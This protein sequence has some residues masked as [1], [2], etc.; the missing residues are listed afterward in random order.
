MKIKTF[1][2][3]NFKEILRDP[4]SLIFGIALPVFL[5]ILMNTIQKKAGVEIFELTNFT[6][7]I[8]VFSFSFITMFSSVL[9]AKDR[10][11]SFLTRLFA[12]PMKA[13]DYII[14]YSLPLI[15]ISILQAIICYGTALILGLEFSIN[16]VYSILILIP[17]SLL[18]I[19]TG[20][21]IGTLC[22]DKQSSGVTSILIQI[23]ALS[24]GMWFPLSA[25][26]GVIETICKSLPYFHSVNLAKDVLLGSYSFM[27]TDIL[28]IVG[29]TIVTFFIA[30]M[31]F[32]RKMKN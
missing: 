4:F 32:R 13:S 27:L 8:A 18:F 9:I 2:S 6:P 11:S 15:P 28:W 25:V 29:Y 23:V 26:G 30:I 31:L 24:S 7:G 20:L 19:A 5:L 3:R 1:A 17:V 10:T 16:I 21:L 14:G 22:T 12:S